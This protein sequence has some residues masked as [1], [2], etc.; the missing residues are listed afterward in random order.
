[1]LLFP[2]KLKNLAL[3][4]FLGFFFFYPTFNFFATITSCKVREKINALTCL[5]TQKHSF[6]TPFCLNT[7]VQD[8]SKNKWWVDFNPLCLCNFMQKIR[9]VQSTDFPQNLKNLILN[10]F[11]V[12][13]FKRESPPH[14]KKFAFD[15]FFTF[16][17]TCYC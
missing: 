1:M 13:N 9:R 16:M 8:F 6:W 12:K 17:P 14:K 11:W 15:Y 3:R 4:Q 5:K 10:P 2:I 7:Q